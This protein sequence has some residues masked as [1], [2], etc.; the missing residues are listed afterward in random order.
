MPE[1]E[2]SILPPK[3][4]LTNRRKFMRA[5]IA[6][7]IAAVLIVGVYIVE[8]VVD[9]DWP[10]KVNTVGMIAAIQ[11]LPKGTQVVLIKPDGSVIQSPGYV[12]GASDREPVWRPDGNR[13]VFVSDREPGQVN[14]YRWNPGSN[15][16]ERRSETSGTYTNLIYCDPDATNGQ[17]LVASGGKIVQFDAASGTTG[18]ILPPTSKAINSSEGSVSS[19]EAMYGNL[20]TSFKE[21]V[22]F[23][24]G[25]ILAILRGDRGETLI[26]QDMK[27]NANGQF[28]P[29]APL[30]TG[31]KIDI[32][33]CRRTGAVVYAVE[34]FRFPDPNNV[35]P[36]F[37]KNGKVVTPFRHLLAILDPHNPLQPGAIMASQ[38]DR[39]VFAQPVFSPDGNS[40]LVSVGTYIG[41]ANVNRTGILSV[42]ARQG[43][44][45]NPAGIHRGAAFDPTFSSDGHT[46]AYVVRDAAGVGTI[47]LMNSDG[48][49][50]KVLTEG[51]GN[52]GSPKFSPQ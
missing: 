40:V 18:P 38:N 35:P 37:V 20:G 4:P 22:S 2:S 12:E 7:G 26:L 25:Y 32:D 50:D 6:V 15:H 52:F 45:A 28:N 9:F 17:P 21:A 14:L 43:G 48:S 42:P 47:H 51:K 5:M 16:V 41:E 24:N 19:M 33:Y 49:D 27:P 44:G 36:E 31:D 23:G 11:Y 34:G 30:A 39:N 46:I 29:P 13:L 3:Q 10:A 1:H 8:R